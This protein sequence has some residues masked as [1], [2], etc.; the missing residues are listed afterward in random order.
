MIKG[1]EFVSGFDNGGSS[2][3]GE[4]QKGNDEMMDLGGGQV[5]IGWW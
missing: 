1:E 2:K 4:K 3:Q 5:D